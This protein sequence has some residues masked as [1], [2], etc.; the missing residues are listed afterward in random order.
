MRK[1]EIERSPLMAGQ[2]WLDGNLPL[3]TLTK[4]SL[5]YAMLVPKQ[6]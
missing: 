1:D 3:C 4:V 6:G 5:F 2:L